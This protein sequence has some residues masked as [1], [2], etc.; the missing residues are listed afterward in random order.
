MGLTCRKEEIEPDHLYCT[1]L[2]LNKEARCSTPAKRKE[3]GDVSSLFD[4]LE[5]DDEEPTDL[6]L[7]MEKFPYQQRH[8]HHQ[9][10]PEDRVVLRRPRFITGNDVIPRHVSV[11]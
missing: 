10:G 8:F 2:A 1:L 4:P 7:P 9:R 5:E 6:P 11:A 3:W